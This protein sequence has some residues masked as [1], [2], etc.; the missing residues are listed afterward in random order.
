MFCAKPNLRAGSLFGPSY[1]CTW[2]VAK[3]TRS[4]SVAA[5]GDDDDDDDNNNN[6]N[7]NNNNG[8]DMI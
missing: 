2:E 3:Q 6:N 1:G 8:N 7:N 5:R 4:V